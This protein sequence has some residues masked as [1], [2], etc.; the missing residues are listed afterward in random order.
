MTSGRSWMRLGSCSCCQAWNMWTISCQV[1][2]IFS[3]RCEHGQHPHT[4]QPAKPNHFSDFFSSSPSLDV[5]GSTITDG[6]GSSVGRAVKIGSW[7]EGCGRGFSGEAAATYCFWITGEVWFEPGWML[8]CDVL[9]GGTTCFLV[10][11][12]GS[13]EGRSMPLTGAE[14]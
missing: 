13:L 5:M 7:Y 3:T 10:R 12:Y 4:F 1:C 8:A 14:H 6:W 11:K 2:S 9:I